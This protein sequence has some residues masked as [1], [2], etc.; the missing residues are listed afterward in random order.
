[1]STTRSELLDRFALP[2]GFDTLLVDDASLFPQ[3]E[4]LCGVILGSRAICI[5][6]NSTKPQVATIVERT[7]RFTLLVPLPTDRKART[8]R[9]A[10]ASTIVELPEHLRRSLTW[11]QD[12]EMVAHADFKIATDIDVYF[13]DPHSPW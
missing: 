10:I 3:T 4:I 13:C 11:D 2:S 8:V 1:V 7:T 6:R 5:G 9:D 12:K